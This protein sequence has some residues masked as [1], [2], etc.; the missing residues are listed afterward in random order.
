MGQS[1]VKILLH[2]VFSTKNRAN[3]IK[4]EF[5]HELFGYINGIVEGNGAKLFIVNGVEDH[6][7]LLVSCGK[8]IDVSELVGD[9]KRSSTTWLKKEKGQKRF[10]WQRGY[11]AFSVGQSQKDTVVRYIER[12]KEHHQTQTFQ[13]EFLELLQKY[14]VQYDERY[15]WD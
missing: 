10:A 2:I 5:E 3:L 7:H 15:L 8:K 4:P 13:E 12:Q 6:I 9:I 11:G 1:L 14:E